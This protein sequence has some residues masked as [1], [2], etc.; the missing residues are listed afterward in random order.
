VS[1]L[2]EGQ[3]VWSDI[4]FG[5]ITGWSEFVS[6]NHKNLTVVLNGVAIASRDQPFAASKGTTIILV[7]LN[8][9][10]SSSIQLLA[11]EE[12][13]SVAGSSAVALVRIIHTSP[14]TPPIEIKLNETAQFTNVEYKQITDY[15]EINAGNYTLSIFTAAINHTIYEHP[16]QLIG[17]YTYTLYVE[18]L[19]SSLQVQ[20]GIDYVPPM[21]GYVRFFHTS[22]NTASVDLVVDWVM[23]NAYRNIGFMG[24]SSYQPYL[25]G[26]HDLRVLPTDQKTPVLSEQKMTLATGSWNSVLF[27]GLSAAENQTSTLETMVIPDA[28]QLPADGD[29]LIRF[30]SASPNA[31]ALDLRANGVGIFSNVTYKTHTEYHTMDA[32]VYKIE[33]F[34]TGHSDVLMGSDFDFQVSSGSAIY[35]LIA[36]GIYGEPSFKILAFRDHGAAPPGEPS[37][38]P[39]KKGLPAW[40]IG[41]IVAAVIVAVI[42]IAAGGFILYR[43]KRRAGYSEISTHDA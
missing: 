36:E 4:E 33:L 11:K 13:A 7:G 24:A 34:Q 19:A 21:N 27:L 18:G 8:E 28:S 40:A 31:P 35:T 5:K 15:K 29:V 17:G 26:E 20:Q 9:V 12:S 39:T 3:A 23:N 1:V 6:A 22:A 32:K 10:N 25:A 16:M 37:V 43:R 41:L 2:L 42:A 14:N 38:P 30:I